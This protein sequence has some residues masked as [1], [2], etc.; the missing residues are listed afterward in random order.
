VG[1][2]LAD[3]ES[4]ENSLLP[5]ELQ[6]FEESLARAIECGN[7]LNDFY[8]HFIGSSNEIST[9]FQDVNMPA[10]QD[11]L[12]KTLT[13]T[14]LANTDPERVDQHLQQIGKYHQGLSIPKVMYKAW[15][16]ALI[17]VLHACDPEFSTE[18]ER[19]WHKA[20]HVAICK[21]HEGYEESV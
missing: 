6:L 10:L 11:K 9:I 5:E 1:R 7:F 18:L 2:R 14:T 21:M 3:T 13:L 19:I 8:E 17:C 20:I 16:D 12:A 15:A 4:T